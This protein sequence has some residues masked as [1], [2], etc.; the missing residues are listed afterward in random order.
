[1]K[2]ILL[3]L[4]VLIL[5]SCKTETKKI[6]KVKS[7]TISKVKI[8]SEDDKSKVGKNTYE[9]ALKRTHKFATELNFDI[10]YIRKKGL[11]DKKFLAE[12]LGLF[13]KLKKASKTDI[14]KENINQKIIPFYQKTKEPNFH[15]MAKVPD[16]LFK[17]NSMSYMRVLW[18]LDE[19]EFDTNFYKKELA[20]IQTRMDNH[21]KVRGEW[22][23]AVFDKYYDYFKIKKPI[24]LKY[25]HKLKGPISYE[26]P[27]S[28]YN[29]SKAYI[30]THF[31]F[32]AYDYGNKTTQT[33]FTKSEM[34]Y[35]TNILPQIITK[36]ETQ[37]N[38]DLVSELLTC[39]V[40]INK[41]ETP[42]FNKSYNRLLNRQNKDGSFGNYEKYR[43]K[44]GSDVEFRQY[45]HTT[46]VSIEMFI[47]HNFRK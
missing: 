13:L 26:R 21:M 28:F 31:V 5:I 27:L 6:T 1:M 16:K 25:A 3:I 23:K 7:N 9:E 17:K 36:F 11:A 14:E 42:A 15:N 32:A 47:E 12:Y 44:I 2:K 10:D 37:N 19:L 46:L 34:N 30:L 4:S 8:T 18:L 33:R 22:Q 43:K 41:D 20:K 24:T 45:L 35:L 40:L 38:D 39:L 29:R